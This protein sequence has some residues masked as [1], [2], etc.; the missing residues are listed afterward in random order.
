MVF[1]NNINNDYY[2][3]QLL[4]QM[5][6]QLKIRPYYI[7]HPKD[8]IGTKHFSISIEE[9]INIFN[10]L[11]GNTSG[12]AIPTYVYNSTNGLGKIPLTSQILELQDKEHN[13]VL[14]TW[15]GKQIIINI[16]RKI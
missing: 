12:L 16:E 9:G 13:V 10:K 15:E 11:R 3:V 5:L 8:V 6:I 14:N 7:F 4:N 2:I 1:L